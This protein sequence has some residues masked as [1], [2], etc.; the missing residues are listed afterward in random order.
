MKR[1]E[2]IFG[3]KGLSLKRVIIQ[4]GSKSVPLFKYAKPFWIKAMAEKQSSQYSKSLSVQ[5]V[6][7]STM[8]L[9][10]RVLYTVMFDPHQKLQRKSPPFQCHV[11]ARDANMAL[12]KRRTVRVFHVCKTSLPATR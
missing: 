1:I 9:T 3:L 10:T 8:Q 11:S 2:K 12:L 5:Q 4:T 6:A 7:V